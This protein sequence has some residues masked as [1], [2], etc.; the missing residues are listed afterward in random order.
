MSE[1]NGFSRR[2]ALALG[3]T[4]LIG[5][6]L[7][8]SG[9]AVLRGGASHPVWTATAA[10]RSGDKLLVPLTELVRV[11]AGGA[12]LVRPEGTLPELLVARD[13]TGWRVVAADCTHWG[14]TVDWEASAAEWTCPCHGSRFAAD[15]ALKEGPAEEPLLAP[16][17][18]IEGDA[19]AIDLAPLRK[20]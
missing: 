7:M 13:S 1:D 17:A 2:D 3:G 10:A 18:Q 6:G 5:L 12:L 19:L 4:G 16:P 15:G 9:C 20:A 11:E 14:C 8:H